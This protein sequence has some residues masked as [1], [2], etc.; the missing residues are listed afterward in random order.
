MTQPK[1]QMPEFN[2]FIIPSE[3]SD[4]MYCLSFKSNADRAKFLRAAHR[5]IRADLVEKMR[6]E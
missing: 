4:F 5:G 6:G 2:A 1:E 3:D